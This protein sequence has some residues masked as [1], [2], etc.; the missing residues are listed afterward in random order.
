MGSSESNA[1]YTVL[2]YPLSSLAFRTFALET[3]PP[4]LML[5]S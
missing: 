1:I 4:Q 2:Y 3:R 5:K